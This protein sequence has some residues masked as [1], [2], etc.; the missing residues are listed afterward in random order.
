MNGEREL[1]TLAVFVHGLT[2]FGH[3]LGVVYNYRKARR[4]DLDVVIHAAALLYDV[5]AAVKHAGRR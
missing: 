3:A 5:R 2:A 4:V 1:E